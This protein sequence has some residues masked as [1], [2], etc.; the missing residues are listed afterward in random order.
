MAWNT[1]HRGGKERLTNRSSLLG[2]SE[3]SGLGGRLELR[4]EN[5]IESA[6]RLDID[7][8]IGSLHDKVRRLKDISKDIEQ[9]T[10]N[11]NELLAGLEAT[12]VQGQA[13]VKNTMRR[14]NIQLNSSGYASPMLLVI[15]FALL[16]FFA[17]YIWSK[18]R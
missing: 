14:L 3:S 17:V 4:V 8:E 2:G 15:L 13:A 16:C 9:E 11:R 5:P 6:G 12:M 18:F 7:A 1:S 10:K